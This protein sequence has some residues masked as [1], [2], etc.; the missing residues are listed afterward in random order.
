MT[1]PKLIN[2][3]ELLH[4]LREGSSLAFN[5][6]YNCYKKRLAANLLK[7]LR[8]EEL[9]KDALQDLFIKVWNNRTSI[10]ADLSFKAYLFRMAENLVVDYY[11]KASRNKDLQQKMLQVE[12]DN[13]YNNVDDHLFSGEKVVLVQ[14][15]INKLPEQQR[16]AYT[17]H[18]LEGLSHKEI[19]E[20]MELSTDT[21]NKYIYLAH[22]FV[23]EQIVASPH[24]TVILLSSA[25]IA[26]A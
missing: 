13:V 2:E 8:D 23:K 1:N 4:Q 5:E 19:S 11:R 17:L 16:K 9:A 18:K 14:Q 15:I 7:L 24:F 3:Y 21:I 20:L 26:E 22:K 6:L 25:I 12:F 10:N